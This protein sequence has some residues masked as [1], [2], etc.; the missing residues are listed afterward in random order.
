MQELRV[1][2][3]MAITSL[4]IFHHHKLFGAGQKGLFGGVGYKGFL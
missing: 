4:F 3:E 1:V 2:N